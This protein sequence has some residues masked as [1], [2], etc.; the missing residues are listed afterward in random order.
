LYSTNLSLEQVNNLIIKLP[1][2]DEQM[3]IGSI[4][5]KLDNQIAFKTQLDKT[6]I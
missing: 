3:Q 1:N 5:K 4:S 2:E 6:K